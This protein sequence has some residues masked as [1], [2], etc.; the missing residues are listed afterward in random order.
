MSKRKSEPMTREAVSRIAR[1]IAVETG[2]KIPPKSFAS[3]A[4]AIVQQRQTAHT[5]KPQPQPQPQPKS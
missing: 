5:P 3:R 2:G 1:S 4:D